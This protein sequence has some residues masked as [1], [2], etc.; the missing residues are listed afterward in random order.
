M[1]KYLIFL[2]T[3]I[4]VLFSTTLSPAQE[5]IYWDVVAKIREEGFNQSKVME[6]L[7]YMCDIHGQRLAGSPGYNKALVWAKEKFEE[8]GAENV[9][10]EPYGKL[11]LGWENRYMSVHML[12]PRYQPLI[13]FPVAWTRG[14]NGKTASNVVYVNIKAIEDVSGLEKYRDKVRNAIVFIE[15]KQEITPLFSSIN[16]RR[17]QE[18]LDN[19]TEYKIGKERD[20]FKQMRPMFK[21]LFEMKEQLR[22]YVD[23]FD[24]AG[25]AVLVAPSSGNYGCVANRYELFNV[26]EN[27]NDPKPMPVVLMAAPHYNSILRIIERDVPAELE[28]EIKNEWDENDLND[29]NLTADLTGTDLKDEF[30]MMGGHFDAWHMGNGASDDGVGCAIAMEAI[31]ILKTIGVKPRRTIRAAFFGAEEIM[32]SGSFGYVNRHFARQSGNYF[33]SEILEYL[34]DYDKFSAFFCFDNGAGR[35]RGVYMQRNPYVRPIFEA[36]MQPFHDLGMTHLVPDDDGGTD[37]LPF[38]RVGLPGFQ[39]IQDSIAGFGYHSNFD[40]YDYLIPEDLMQASVILASFVYHAAMRD[41]RIP[42]KPRP[43]ITR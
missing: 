34:P 33:T 39:F 7:S 10:I 20:T 21:E 15:P 3:A 9:K 1:R 6:M 43:E 2:I 16:S 23:F 37:I 40:V 28:V 8:I 31:R 38:D 14:T 24:E 17:T 18:S 30:V 27:K 32:I 12:K 36:W 35:I 4:C 22:S 26:V 13:A 19:M 41:E 11:G 42:R 5:P 29:Y 25:A